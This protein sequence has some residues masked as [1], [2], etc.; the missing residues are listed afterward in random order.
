MNATYLN[1]HVELDAPS[2]LVHA[3]FDVRNDT[4]EPWR[5]AEGFGV[6]HHLFDAADAAF[7]A[8]LSGAR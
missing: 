4:P 6:G 5:A 1:Q 8:A 3:E 7:S 2:R